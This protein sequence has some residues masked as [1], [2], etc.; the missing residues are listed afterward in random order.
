MK[1]LMLV[2]VIA[3]MAFAT[4]IDGCTEIRSAVNPVQANDLDM[5]LAIVNDWTV[6]NASLGIDIFESTTGNYIL[7]VE[8]TEMQI[9][10]YDLTGAPLGTL[11]LDTENASCF[12]MA[13]NNDPDT[14]TYYT[15]DWQDANLYYTE[16]FGAS[17]STSTPNPAGTSAR[18]MDFDG[19][20]YWATNATNGGL[21]RF[22]PGVGQENVA[23]P[24]V[25][26][27]PSGLAVFPYNGNTGVAV[28]TYNTHNIYF[29]EWDGSTMS[30]IGSAPCPVSGIGA[31]YGLS[32]SNVTDTMFWTYQ[33][34]S[35]A[36]HLAEFSFELT[37]LSRTSWGSIKT[38]F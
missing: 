11:T 38:S 21:W 37:S 4:D 8:K 6:P 20:N 10:A 29:Y 33:D 26:D 36:Y 5:T 18:G 7:T 3:S 19:T 13:W 1:F 28:T 34:A 12:G 16:D 30:Y 15:N 31:S 24:E 32:Y 23:I 2:F 25:T 22:S 27:Q 35:N 17:W 14:D 9:Q